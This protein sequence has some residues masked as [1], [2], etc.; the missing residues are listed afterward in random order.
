MKIKTAL[1]FAKDI[2]AS[3]I[4]AF[5]RAIMEEYESDREGIDFTVETDEGEFRFISDSE[6]ETIHRESIEELVD[7]CY[8][9]EKIKNNLGNLANYLN[10]NYDGFARDC[11]INYGY[12]HHFASYD[13]NEYEQDNFYM[14]RVN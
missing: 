14:F 11:L 5:A 3:D 12:G 1:K 7:D 4:R 8:D 2:S 6:I 10:F 9:L 13:G